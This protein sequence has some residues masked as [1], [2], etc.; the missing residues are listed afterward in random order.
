M[1]IVLAYDSFEINSNESKYLMGHAEQ[2]LNARIKAGK[3]IEEMAKFLGISFESYRDLEFH[4]DEVENCISIQQVIKLCK[5]L[6]IKPENL[7]KD[8]INNQLETI[9][10]DNLSERIRE[11][12]NK[13]QM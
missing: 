9:S 4:D 7:F 8:E 12:L 5:E 1:R 6:R 11:E 10:L 2:L 13:T 3:T